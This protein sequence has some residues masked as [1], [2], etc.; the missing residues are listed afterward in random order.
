[1][2]VVYVLSSL[3]KCALEP[4]PIFESSCVVAGEWR[5]FS[6]GSGYQSLIRCVTCKYVLPFQGRL[7][8]R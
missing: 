6:V 3:E 2:L 4:S 5:E 8:L 7:S 1:M